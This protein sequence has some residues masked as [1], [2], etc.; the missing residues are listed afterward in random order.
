MPRPLCFVIMPYGRKPTQA[1]A[2]RGPGEIDFNALWDRAYVPVIESL[3]YDAVRADQDTGSMIITQMLERI[4]YADLVLA[5][6]TIPNGNV[7]YEVG[8][9]HAAKPT[10]CV[11][12]AADWSQPLFD[13]AQL[14]TVRYPLANGDIDDATAQRIR[15]TIS[16]GIEALAVG[17]SPMFEAI[18]G[19]PSSPEPALASTMKQRM[20]E[21]AAFQSAIRGVR[22]LPKPQRMARAQELVKKHGVPPLMASVVFALLLLLRDSIEVPEDWNKL[23]AF[24]D[25]L[26]D[27]F[28]EQSEVQ[29]QR[30]FAVS[31]AG[32]VRDAI[33]QLEVVLEM[34]GPSVE[35]LGLLGGRYKR[36]YRD[37][38]EPFQKQ[39]FLDQAIDCYERGM[40]LDLND[41]YCSSNL[42]RLYRA[43]N[44]KDDLK[45]AHVISAVVNAACE[46]ALRRG[47]TDEWLRPTWLAAAFDDGDADL[48]ED[49]AEKVAA[50][51][52]TRWK[53]ESV[54]ADLHA[55]AQL[56]P[57]EARRARLVGVAD[58]LAEQ[59]GSEG[60]AG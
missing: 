31:Q 22:L 39:Q 2:T 51:G 30:A 23:L 36:L 25:A 1:D 58:K 27:D 15:D 28:R 47:V 6:M 42:P 12:L 37:T 52:V 50:E 4:Y 44:G 60:K 7:Y 56:E 57:D 3:G 55:S 8:I 9:R 35:R 32:D 59:S 45:R 26:P 10:G 53:I 21:L 11:L 18:K 19:Y 16:P 40:D 43:R 49:L 48:A 20:A 13:V 46:R 54:L 5:D 14:R 17:P 38:V 29:S 41:Y 24:I 34:A 33:E